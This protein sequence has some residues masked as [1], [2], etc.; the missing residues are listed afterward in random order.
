MRGEML[1]Q[2]ERSN[3]IDDNTKEETAI[4]LRALKWQAGNSHI[5]LNKEN[6]QNVYSGVKNY[7]NFFKLMPKNLSIS[8]F[9]L[10]F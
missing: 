2:V 3:W 1:D 9:D 8:Y 5:V 6:L 7:K 4:K 10:R